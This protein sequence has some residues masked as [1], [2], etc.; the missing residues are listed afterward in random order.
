MFQVPA[1]G[2][3]LSRPAQGDVPGFSLELPATTIK[4]SFDLT[5]DAVV[6]LT[7]LLDAFNEVFNVNPEFSGGRHR[8]RGN[9]IGMATIPA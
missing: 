9:K 5:A 6:K 4:Y 1:K 3:V 7:A 2:I 8:A